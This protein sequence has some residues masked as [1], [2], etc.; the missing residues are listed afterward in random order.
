MTFMGEVATVRLDRLLLSLGMVPLPDEPD[1]ARALATDCCVGVMSRLK[2]VSMSWSASLRSMS[3]SVSDS[4]RARGSGETG[5]MGELS[6]MGMWRLLEEPLC[7]LSLAGVFGRSPGP[8]AL[9]ASSPAEN[10]AEYPAVI[11][12]RN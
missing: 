1:P 9:G 2:S 7:A 11:C 8:N 5:R 6:P 10:R 12:T 3:V 4:L